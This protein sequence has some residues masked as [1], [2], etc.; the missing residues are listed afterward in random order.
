[1][2][3]I[4]KDAGLMV[5]RAQQHSVNAS[6][7]KGLAGKGGLHRRPIFQIGLNQLKAAAGALGAGLQL[8]QAGAL[9]ENH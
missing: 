8:R 9:D 1:M 7:L 4:T 3:A 5:I 6:P 2:P